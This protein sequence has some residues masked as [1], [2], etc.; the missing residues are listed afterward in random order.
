MKKL[1]FLLLAPVLLLADLMLYYSPYCPH[2]RQVLQYLDKIHKSVPMKNV[3][4][5][6]AYKEELRKKGGLMQVPCLLIDGKPM[7]N[8]DDIVQWMSQHQGQLT[9]Y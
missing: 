6:K 7:Y 4:E 5:D 8:A 3:Y 1:L 2:S 9:S